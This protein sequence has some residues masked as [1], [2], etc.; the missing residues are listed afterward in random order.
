MPSTAHVQPR[1]RRERAQ[2]NLYSTSGTIVNGR[3]PYTW[4]D[5]NAAVNQPQYVPSILIGVSWRQ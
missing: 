4:S 5:A 2:G 3:S 1:T